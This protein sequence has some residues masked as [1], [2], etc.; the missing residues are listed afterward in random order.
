M[1]GLG[2]PK[3]HKKAFHWLLKSAEQGFAISQGAVGGY[4]GDGIGVPQDLVK[5]Y[6]WFSVAT[7]NG[8][9]D[10]MSSRD[11]TAQRLTPDQLAKGQE[12][13][14]SYFEKYQPK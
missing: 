5:A 8:V 2:V 3:D 13:A 10:F 4:Y 14:A 11:N 9:E 6:A 1:N 7:A 12:L